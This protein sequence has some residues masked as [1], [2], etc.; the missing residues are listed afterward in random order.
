MFEVEHSDQ[1][2][3][4]HC[5]IIHSMTIVLNTYIL[6]CCSLRIVTEN[7]D[8][9]FNLLVA[10]SVLINTVSIYVLYAT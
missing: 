8:N 10:R 7:C 6:S 1:L 4:L 3:V 2:C 9:C 5:K